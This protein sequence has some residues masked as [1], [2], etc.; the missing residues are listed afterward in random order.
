MIKIT[1]I[2]CFKL[3]MYVFRKQNCWYGSRLNVMNNF[4]IYVLDFI[5][6]KT[7]MKGLELL[8]CHQLNLWAYPRN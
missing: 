7:S 1:L 8:H 6:H 3:L 4:L 2:V 5:G